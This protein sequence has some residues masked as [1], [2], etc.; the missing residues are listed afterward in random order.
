MP[1]HP[2]APSPSACTPCSPRPV[3]PAVNICSLRSE[4]GTWPGRGGYGE[5][6]TNLQTVTVPNI[7]L[8]TCLNVKT[9]HINHTHNSIY[10]GHQDDILALIV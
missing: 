2:P 9:L 4:C 3:K 7:I 6:W 5:R 10:N 8:L 1:P